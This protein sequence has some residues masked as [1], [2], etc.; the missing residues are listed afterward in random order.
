MSTIY[1]YARTGKLGKGL[2]TQLDLLKKAGCTQIFHDTMDNLTAPRPEFDKLMQAVKAGDTIVVIELAKLT[3][4]LLH[5]LQQT[6]VLAERG[7]NIRS[8]KDSIDTSS[9][10]GKVFFANVGAISNLE[11]ALKLERSVIGRKAAKARGRLGG[12]PRTNEAQLEQARIL[13]ENSDYTADEVC[14]QAGVGRRTFFRYLEEV[15]SAA[16]EASKQPPAE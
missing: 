1:G 10:T 5:F 12:R 8:I 15:R 14:E 7:V 16:A 9:S 6:T 2:D 11:K 4:S 13:Y 3:H